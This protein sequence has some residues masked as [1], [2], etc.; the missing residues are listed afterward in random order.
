MV[1]EGLLIGLEPVHGL[2]LLGQNALGRQS[3]T[4]VQELSSLFA[5]VAL[6]AP[7][8]SKN[9]NSH[10][11]E[12][13]AE[14]VQ[15]KDVRWIQILDERGTVVKSRKDGSA[16]LLSG[17]FTAALAHVPATSGGGEIASGWD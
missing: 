4:C 8:L 7:S 9:P 3:H 15:W 1:R 17:H 14:P 13:L 5:S 2:L 12:I 6:G 16:L 11:G 10:P